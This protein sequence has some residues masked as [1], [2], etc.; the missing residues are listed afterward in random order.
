MFPGGVEVGVGP[1]AVVEFEDGQAV[2]E[3][4]CCA[5][6]VHVLAGGGR[7]LGQ[8]YLLGHRAQRIATVHQGSHCF[9]MLTTACHYANVW[10]FIKRQ[11]L[12]AIRM[13]KAADNLKQAQR[14]AM[15]VRPK[16]GGFPVLAEVLRQA[17]VQ[18][19]VWYLPSAQSVYVTELGPVVTLGQ[20]LMTGTLDLPGFNQAALVHA[21]R[22]DQAG[23]TSL[24]EFLLAS[25][26]AGVVSYD[27][28]LEA[29]TVTYYGAGDDSYTETYDAATVPA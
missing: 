26:E 2:P 8:P 3:R 25:W 22:K 11:D 4:P 14:R 9:R 18:R 7:R 24:P 1:E 5:G 28:D 20:P 15:Q 19:N 21:L 16:V 12:G 29:R 23:E 10:S 27:V 13:S 6:E 17:G